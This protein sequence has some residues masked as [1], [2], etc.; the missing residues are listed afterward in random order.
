MMAASK[1]HDEV[2]SLLIENRTDIEAKNKDGESTSSQNNYYCYHYQW[3]TI[4]ARF[5]IL[6]HDIKY[7][8]INILYTKNET[9]CIPIKIHPPHIYI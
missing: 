9:W 2:V 7:I 8:Y 3:S 4:I 5:D 6:Y 1:G